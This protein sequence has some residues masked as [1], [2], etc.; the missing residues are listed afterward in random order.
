MGAIGIS[1]THTKSSTN[2]FVG[3]NQSNRHLRLILFCYALFHLLCIFMVTE[4]CR[5][6]MVVID[7]D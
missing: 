4:C 3:S 5:I 6:A 7:S 2:S 1:F